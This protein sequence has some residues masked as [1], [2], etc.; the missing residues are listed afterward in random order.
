[1]ALVIGDKILAADVNYNIYNSGSVSL[2]ATGKLLDPV[3]KTGTYIYKLGPNHSTVVKHS[4]FGAGSSSSN[5]CTVHTKS[6]DEEDWVYRATIEESTTSITNTY[7]HLFYEVKVTLV[8]SIGAPALGS[9]HTGTFNIDF[10]TDPNVALQGEPIRVL[11]ITMD[12]WETKNITKDINSLALF[13]SGRLGY[14]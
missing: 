6:S 13:E 9:Y 8:V 14:E 11:K 7:D 12:E 1:M 4:S 2:R 3:T 10:L 5:Y